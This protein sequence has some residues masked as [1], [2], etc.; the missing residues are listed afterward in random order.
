M[1][2]D[3]LLDMRSII[4]RV[5]R[6]QKEKF[7]TLYD[8]LFGRELYI[9]EIKQTNEL[10]DTK[11]GIKIDELRQKE[12][13]KALND[14]LLDRKLYIEK[15]KQSNELSDTELGIECDD[16]WDDGKFVELVDNLLAIELKIKK[17]RIY[18][19]GDKYTTLVIELLK[20]IHTSPETVC[21]GCAR[22]Y[23]METFIYNQLNKFLREA[24]V[25]KIGMYGPFVRLLY[26]YFNHPSSMGV[27]SIKVYRAMN[28]KP[29]MIDAYK[30]AAKH[31][32]S[33]RWASFSSTSK[34]LKF[35][36]FWD[37]NTTFIMQLNKISSEEKKA[38]DISFYSQ[39]PE[40]EEVLLKAGIEFTVKKVDYDDRNKKHY[41]Y[42]DVY[43]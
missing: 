6:Q 14:L 1:L 15:M 3:E 40:E 41:I 13:C 8:V 25:T 12:K 42:L 24:D 17:I 5:E 29:P 30:E 21:H 9:E 26:F 10:S 19:E 33:F 39:F 34:N 32:K 20:L 16:S 31:N 37:A 27:D 38:I 18:G 2:Y 7:K 28:L 35:A 11:L 4:E 23:T 43:V 22:L 36:E